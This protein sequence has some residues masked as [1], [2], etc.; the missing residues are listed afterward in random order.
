MRSKRPRV[1][2]SGVV[3]HGAVQGVGADWECGP[4]LSL[5]SPFGTCSPVFILP[6]TEFS[7]S[8]LTPPPPSQI[9]EVDEEKTRLMLSN[10]RVAAEERASSF[11]VGPGEG[12]PSGSGSGRGVVGSSR[13]GTVPVQ[14]LHLHFVLVLCSAANA[15]CSFSSCGV[16]AVPLLPS[17]LLPAEAGA[18]CT[19]TA[20]WLERLPACLDLP[21]SLITPHPGQ[22]THNTHT[23]T[24]TRRWA[25]WWRAA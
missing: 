16:R 14:R 23:Y 20:C 21:P 17:L 8:S 19:C 2:V 1:C 24:H 3:W 12:R 10:K 13:G 5:Q 15:L 25:M 9:T 11:K 18:L 7:S 4:S 6:G 22:H